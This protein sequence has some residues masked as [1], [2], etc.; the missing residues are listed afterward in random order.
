MQCELCQ[1]S[2]DDTSLFEFH[3]F[4][5]GKN[6]RKKKGLENEGCTVCTT[7]G[8]QIHL[9]F[10]NNR[11][12]D[13]LNSVEALKAEMQKYIKWVQKR[14]LENAVTMKKKKRRL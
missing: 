12:R 14:P 13:E 4:F 6:R 5:P 9:M 10:G 2:S 3:H 8:D 7:C 11:L 1:R